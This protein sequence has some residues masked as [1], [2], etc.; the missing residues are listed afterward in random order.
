MSVGGRRTGQLARAALLAV[1][2]A[3]ALS[4]LMPGPSTATT[5]PG[6]VSGTSTAHRM[7]APS[8]LNIVA[9]TGSRESGIGSRSES[10]TSWRWLA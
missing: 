2:A 3:A 9:T 10:A 7:P 8:G 6:F 4:P 5:S 1:A